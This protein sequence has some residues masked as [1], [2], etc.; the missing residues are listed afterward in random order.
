MRLSSLLTIVTVLSTLVVATNVAHAQSGSRGESLPPA[1][2]NAIQ[3]ASPVIDSG[4]A[5]V[6]E[7]FRIN[8]QSTMY[9]SP[10]QSAGIGTFNYADP[11]FSAG[12]DFVN[13][14][15]PNP[16]PYIQ[17]YSCGGRCLEKPPCIGIPSYGGDFCI[18]KAYGRPL[19]GRWPGF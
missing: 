5:G 13:R 12:S 18:G 7:D 4:S 19:F 9:G 1:V 15:N 6:I 17:P 11:T 8:G 2:Q 10:N 14:Y 16:N 3:Q